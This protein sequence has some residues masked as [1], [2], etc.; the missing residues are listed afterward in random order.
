MLR[1][2]AV[3]LLCLGVLAACTPSD[4]GESPLAAPQSIKSRLSTGTRTKTIEVRSSTPSGTSNDTGAQCCTFYAP[5]ATQNSYR[6]TGATGSV[7]TY[8]AD[9][10]DDLPQG[11]KVTKVQAVMHGRLVKLEGTP[12]AGS[13]TN[14]SAKLNGGL[15]KILDFDPGA[16]LTC[17]G[18]DRACAPDASGPEL[19]NGSD[20]YADY[21]VRDDNTLTLT[22]TPASG[23]QVKAEYCIAQIDLKLTYEQP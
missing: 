8:T 3:T 9:F 22:V 18:T 16:A 1:L 23:T 4:P 5:P 17:P 14:I 13:K 2:N 19:G 11:S 6:C 20:A 21:N 12:L 7:T 10:T 15:T